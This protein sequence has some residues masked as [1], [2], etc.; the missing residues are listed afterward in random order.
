MYIFEWL[1]LVS[2]SCS[3]YATTITVGLT[4]CTYKTT[5]EM[6]KLELILSFFSWEM[7]DNHCVRENNAENINTSH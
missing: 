5:T 4:A 7:K 6:N 1:E 3:Y 2:L